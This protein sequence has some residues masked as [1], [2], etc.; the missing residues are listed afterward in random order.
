M[1]ANI[2]IGGKRRY[3]LSTLNVIRHAEMKERIICTAAGRLCAV[4]IGDREAFEV[5][6]SDGLMKEFQ[7]FRVKR[8]F[9]DA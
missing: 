7:S 8:A 1:A 5:V 6:P 3:G 9:A 2:L 4:L